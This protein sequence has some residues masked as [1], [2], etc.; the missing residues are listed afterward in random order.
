MQRQISLSS[1]SSIVRPRSHLVKNSASQLLQP[2]PVRDPGPE[3]E[4]IREEAPAPVHVLLVEDDDLDTEAIIRV[5]GRQSVRW[6][7]ASTLA[8]AREALQHGPHDLVLA[9]YRLPDGEGTSLVALAAPIPVVVITGNSGVDQSVAALRAGAADY[10]IKDLEGRYAELVPIAIERVLER[11]REKAALESAERLRREADALRQ[12]TERFAAMVS[13]VLMVPMHSIVHMTDMLLSR[14]L[15]R[16]AKNYAEGV[17]T[18]AAQCLQLVHGLSGYHGV[19]LRTDRLA[20]VPFERVLSRAMSGP[21]TM[22]PRVVFSYGL[23]PVLRTDEGLMDDLIQRLVATA[24]RRIRPDQVD[25]E[26]IVEASESAAGVSL[27]FGWNGVPFEPPEDSVFDL[28]RPGGNHS[29]D[30]PICRR[31]LEVHNGSI[32][33]WLAAS[34]HTVI[35]MNFPTDSVL[36]VL[37]DSGFGDTVSVDPT[38]RD[39]EASYG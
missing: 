11:T 18:R 5:L 8:A 32:G 22:G 15:D 27:R 12:S 38:D 13:S 2:D 10:L 31:I 28:F 25:L 3:T 4:R 39:A 26:V 21:Q 24:C 34:G 23:L 30:L 37:D 29:F 1:A 17:S 33:T 6:T 9:D 20:S 35:E 14:K 7:R 36:E 19:E 16:L